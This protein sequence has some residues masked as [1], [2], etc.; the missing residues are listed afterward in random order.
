MINRLQASPRASPKMFN[1]EKNRFL[2][3]FRNAILRWLVNMVIGYRV[4]NYLRLRACLPAGRRRGAARYS[5]LRL[6]VGLATAARMA[7]TLTV[8]PAMSTAMP[9]AATKYQGLMSMR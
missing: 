1:P 5:L 2:Q 4:L 3:R 6:F 7:C 9:P 8:T